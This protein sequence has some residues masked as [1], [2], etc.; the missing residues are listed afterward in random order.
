MP[1]GLLALL[2][3]LNVLPTDPSVAVCVKFQIALPLI[4]LAAAPIDPLILMALILKVV[5]LTST[6]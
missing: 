6:Y 3:S 1:N 2:K 5:S 4:L